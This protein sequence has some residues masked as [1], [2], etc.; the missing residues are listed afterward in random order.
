MLM[1]SLRLSN[2]LIASNTGTGPPAPLGKRRYPTISLPLKGIRTVSKG[3]SN[4]LLAARNASSALA[5]DS[6]FPAD[7]GTGQRPNEY[8]R[9]AR[10]YAALALAGSLASS[11]FPSAI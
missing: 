6:F 3:G 5:Y 8:N 2:P 7:A 4:V 10:M 1:S 11:D 9:H